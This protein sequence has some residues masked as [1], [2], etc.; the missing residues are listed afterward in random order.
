MLFFSQHINLVLKLADFDLETRHPDTGPN[1]WLLAESI[2][3]KILKFEC[4]LS[5]WICREGNLGTMQNEVYIVNVGLESGNLQVF[6]APRLS[7]K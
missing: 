7:T 1:F 4:T 3:Q 2:R 6:V 5:C